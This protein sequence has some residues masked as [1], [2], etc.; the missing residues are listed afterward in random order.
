MANAGFMA[1]RRNQLMKNPAVSGEMA[2][3]A[4][5]AQRGELPLQSL[6]ALQAC[7]NTGQLRIDQ[8]VDVAT[9]AFRVCHKRQ[10]ALDVRQGNIQNP[11]MVDEGQPFHM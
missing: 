2:Y 10:Q 8:L 4:T 7:L 11:A 3:A 6:H 1:R 5:T 9:V